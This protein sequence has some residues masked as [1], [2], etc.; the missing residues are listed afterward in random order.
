[1]ENPWFGHVATFRKEHPGMSYTVPLQ[2]AKKTYTPK[3]KDCP[4]CPCP[5]KNNTNNTKKVVKSK[6]SKKSKKGKSKRKP[7]AWNHHVNAFR[8]SH[9]DL[10]FSEVLKEA[11]KT[12]KK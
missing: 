12:Y 11:K 7:T 6:K 4:P 10:K 8:K 5:S 2:Q 9:P 3:I 1:M